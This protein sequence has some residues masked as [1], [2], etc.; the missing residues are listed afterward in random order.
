MNDNGLMASLASSM[1]GI[2]PRSDSFAFSARDGL[3]YVPYDNFPARLHKG[4]RVQT[5]AEAS[6]SG[7][8][9][10]HIH[11]DWNGREIA[12]AMINENET[13]SEYVVSLRKAVQ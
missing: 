10:I 1:R 13:N 9:E 6:S 7:A 12:Y 3:D 4:E 8:R 2:A 5:A 11:L